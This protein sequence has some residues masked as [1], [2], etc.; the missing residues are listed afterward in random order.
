MFP[1]DE[2]KKYADPLYTESNGFIPEAVKLQLLLSKEE[3]IKEALIHFQ[4][5]NLLK[6]I[7]DSQAIQYRLFTTRPFFRLLLRWCEKSVRMDST[8]S[9]NRWSA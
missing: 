5:I 9:D 3:D 6:P 8:L 7:L 4:K 1:A 2:V